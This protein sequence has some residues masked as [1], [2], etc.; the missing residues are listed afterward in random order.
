MLEGMCYLQQL[1]KCFPGG[2]SVSACSEQGSAGFKSPFWINLDNCHC[3]I[4]LIFTRQLMVSSV[5]VLVQINHVGVCPR[6]FIHTITHP[7]TI[8]EVTCRS[9][10]KSVEYSVPT[11]A[12]LDCMQRK[13]KLI[14]TM[15]LTLKQLQLFQV[16]IS[17]FYGCATVHHIPKQYACITYQK[18]VPMLV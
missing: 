3:E 12:S 9:Y 7:F 5:L 14:P 15:Y 17:C 13:L 6:G 4:D 18:M 8:I 16:C 2:E 1:A 11:Y 10:S